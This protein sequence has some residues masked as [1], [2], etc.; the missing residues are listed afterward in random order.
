[1]V[2][3][4]SLLGNVEKKEFLPMMA[5]SSL[6]A[7]LLAREAKLKDVLYS[8]ESRRRTAIKLAKSAFEHV[9][10][11][12]HNAASSVAAS[13]APLNGTT[14]SKLIRD[15]CREVSHEHE[16]WLGGQEEVSRYP[17]WV[18]NY[19]PPASI[20]KGRSSLGNSR[21]SDSTRLNGPRGGAIFKSH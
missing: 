1:M 6:A 10:G 15:M 18:C 14:T 19:Q 21:H 16:Q 11:L 12:W 4:D 2:P 8:A 5:S 9:T 13:A 17:S 20:W 7:I 3:V